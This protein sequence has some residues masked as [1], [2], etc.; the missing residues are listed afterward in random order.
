[1]LP[2]LVIR[3]IS[4]EYWANPSNDAVLA[5]EATTLSYDVID[6]RIG[7]GFMFSPSP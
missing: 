5:L 4:D 3:T 6:R 7:C 2:M 1:M